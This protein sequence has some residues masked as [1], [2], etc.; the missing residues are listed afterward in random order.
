MVGNAAAG[1]ERIGFKMS[2][3]PSR[4]GDPSWA[5]MDNVAHSH[6]SVGLAVHFSPS[7][8]CVEVTRFSAYRIWTMAV[9]GSASYGSI[10][11][12]DLR[13]ADSK[14]GI[15]WMTAGPSPTAHVLAVPATRVLVHE[16]LFLGRSRSNAECSDA[17]LSAGSSAQQC[18]GRPSKTDKWA[19]PTMREQLALF[20]FSQS[21]GIAIMTPHKAPWYSGG[22]SYPALSAEFRVV[23]TTFARFEPSA[24]GV[25]SRILESP[26]SAAEV[27][28]PVFFSDLELI[29][30]D[31]TNMVKFHPPKR[32]WI[33]ISDCVTMDCD[34]PKFHLLH[35]LDGSLTGG[36]ANSSII[37]EAEFMNEFR[38]DGV[39]P[40]GYNIPAKALY[41]LN[42]YGR[43][44]L[45]SDQSTDFELDS[46]RRGLQLTSTA[47]SEE[48]V[49]YNGYGVYRAGCTHRPAWKAYE[50]RAVDTVNAA[51]GAVIPARLVIESL[52]KD[53]ETR[54][55][56]PVSLISGGYVTLINGGMD[57]GWCFGY[58]CLKRLSTFH[59]TI[60]D[61]RR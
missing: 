52:D 9:F 40:T 16:A 56:V 29:D 30:I 46:R 50:C 27:Q 15:Y 26:P 8:Q 41:D 57:H 54:S 3:P 12:Q 14:T 55:L 39:T 53:S 2:V 42:P 51:G 45:G 5:F 13:I 25:I 4:C 28:A 20:T 38:A 34:G 32:G 22:S 61:P 59:T 44:R 23:D 10:T 11:F 21:A 17:C 37:A 18:I 19:W 48:E 58:T 31:R 49:A 33:T 36:G 7:A 24:C 60:M 43:R 47:R 6:S 35:D 1:S